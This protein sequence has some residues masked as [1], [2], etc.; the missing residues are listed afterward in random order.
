MTLKLIA[1][2]LLTLIASLGLVAPAFAQSQP[3]GVVELFTSQG[4]SSYPPA[5]ANLVTLSQRADL[6]VLSFAVT[7]WDRLGWKDTFGKFEF[8]DRQIIYELAPEPVWVLYAA[9]G[10]Q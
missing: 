3:P 7:Y 10:G 6:L 4:C 5:N 9:H 1:L 8:A 2:L